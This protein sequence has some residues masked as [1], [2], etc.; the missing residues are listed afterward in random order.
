M[1]D[2]WAVINWAHID[3]ARHEKAMNY[4]KNFSS[5]DDLKTKDYT[6]SIV[7]FG[8]GFVC[9]DVYLTNPEHQNV[10][11]GIDSFVAIDIDKRYEYEFDFDYL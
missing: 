10:E 4:K 2:T 6:F 7:H 8:K 5:D 1:R 11:Q 9:L 3:R